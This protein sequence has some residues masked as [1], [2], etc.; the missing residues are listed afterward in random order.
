MEE[1]LHQLMLVLYP[2]ICRVLYIPSGAGVF[3]INSM[4]KDPFEC[5]FANPHR[6]LKDSSPD[7]FALHFQPLLQKANHL[8]ET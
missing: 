3:S 1:I 7:L 4:S 2:I 6:E 5:F 8:R